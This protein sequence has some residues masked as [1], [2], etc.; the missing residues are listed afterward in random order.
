VYLDLRA[1]LLQIRG[2]E[3]QYQ[4]DHHVTTGADSGEGAFI[5]ETAPDVYAVAIDLG[6]E[7]G[8]VEIA[9]GG[10]DPYPVRTSPERTG[11][12]V[13]TLKIGQRCMLNGR[14][15]VMYIRPRR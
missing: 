3:E 2:Y 10:V 15:T 12:Q 13:I 14:P 1:K 11:I 4:V 6:S 8:Y 7:R 9:G 5:S